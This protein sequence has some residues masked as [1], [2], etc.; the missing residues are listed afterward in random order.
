MCVD[1]RSSHVDWIKSGKGREGKAREG[2]WGNM[3]RKQILLGV[4]EK[5]V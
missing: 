3:F 5:G 2:S 1:S 4:L